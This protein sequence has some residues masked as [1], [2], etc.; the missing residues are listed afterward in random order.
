MNQTERKQRPNDPNK[1]NPVDLAR[2]LEA[3]DVYLWANKAKI[4]EAVELA[5]D[6]GLDVSYRMMAEASSQ[7]CSMWRRVRYIMPGRAHCLDAKQWD[8]LIKWARSE[9][10]RRCIAGAGS[11]PAL[12]SLARRSGL[13]CSPLSIAEALVAAH[14]GLVEGRPRMPIAE[15]GANEDA[16]ILE[17][18]DKTQTPM[19]T[20]QR[21]NGVADTYGDM[22]A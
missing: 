17:G 8:K 13:A 21:S 20:R 11:F 15:H 10:G 5:S 7:V 9:R 18:K 14:V 19:S 2:W 6:D 4:R 22:F 12:S 3:L 1:A 16:T